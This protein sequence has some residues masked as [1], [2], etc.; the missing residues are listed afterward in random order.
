MTT[1]KS[2]L[3]PLILFLGAVLRAATLGAAALWYDESVTA[4]RASLPF[5]QF[6]AAR[7]DNSGCLLLDLILRLFVALGGRGEIY[8]ALTTPLWLLRLPSLLASFGALWLVW[9]IMRELQ[10]TLRQQVVAAA[11]AA[12]LPG[13]L[14]IG[15]DARAYSLLSFVFLLGLWYAL[16]GRLVGMAACLGL[17]TY[18]HN[19]G[20]VFALAVFC[21]AIYY[22]PSRWRRILIAGALAALT[23]V[24]AAVRAVLVSVDAFGIYQPWQLTLTFS[25]LVKSMVTAIWVARDQAFNLAG[26]LLGIASLGLLYSRA[27]QCRARNAL[28]MACL[29]PLLGL[30]L[31]SVF[32]FNIV[33]YRVLMPCIFPLALFLGWEFGHASPTRYRLALAALW[34]WLLVLDLTLWRPAD[35]GAYLDQAAALVRSQ[36]RT[37][38]VIVYAAR[39][40]ALPMLYYLPDLAHYDWPG[41]ANPLLNEPGISIRDTGDPA[42][43]SRIWLVVPQDG[44]ITAPEMASLEAA[45]PHRGD[46]VWQ[47]IYLQAATINV[48]LEGK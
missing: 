41:A 47:S 42:S 32:L 23:W 3:P 11:F 21:I 9:L 30:V 26:F 18:C 1:L 22:R 37:G 34:T 45:Y 24:P 40:A 43:A 27:W 16:Q 2:R 10:F 31:A 38:D 20:P 14:W 29:I 12:F 5:W 19:T 15:Q 48:Y 8:L 28:L 4:Y 6:Y 25:W 33:V 13:A 46:P 17:L 44:L 36:W 39:T 7:T 35:R